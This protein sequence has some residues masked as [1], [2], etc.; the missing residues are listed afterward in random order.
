M[1]V[2]C[3]HSC[4]IFAVLKW[5]WKSPLAKQL[6]VI[7]CFPLLFLILD[8]CNR[9]LMYDICLQVYLFI[10]GRLKW[11]ILW[12]RSVWFLLL[13]LNGLLCLCFWSSMYCFL[14]LVYFSREQGF[15]LPVEGGVGPICHIG[16]AWLLYFPVE[17]DIQKSNRLNKLGSLWSLT[18]PNVVIFTRQI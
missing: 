8:L 2:L 11:L 16:V 6:R 15:F 9:F 5:N 12:G 4:G 3:L 10:V 17:H 7:V 13:I 1:I 14:L 18:V